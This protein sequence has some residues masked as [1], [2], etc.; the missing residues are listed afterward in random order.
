MDE[1]GHLNVARLEEACPS[2][3][4]GCGI[5]AHWSVKAYVKK[6]GPCISLLL[7]EDAST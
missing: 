2:L 7:T 5:E 1:S 6:R 3:P 4:G